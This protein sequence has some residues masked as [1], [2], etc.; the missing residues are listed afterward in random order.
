MAQTVKG[1]VEVKQDRPEDDEAED[2]GDDPAG[3][4]S[5][6]APDGVWT[7]NLAE[8]VVERGAQATLARAAQM[9]AWNGRDWRR[10]GM[11]GFHTGDPCNCL[12]D[13]RNQGSRA[14]IKAGILRGTEKASLSD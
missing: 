4:G 1:V 3:D 13:R 2:D 14:T 9:Q 6:E 12:T 5:I 10:S 7:V 11:C 8:A